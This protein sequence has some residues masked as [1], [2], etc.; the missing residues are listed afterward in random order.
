MKGA[1]PRAGGL[2]ALSSAQAIT[3]G[4]ISL[5]QNA[6]RA[7]VRWPDTILGGMH[8]RPEQNPSLGNDDPLRVN[9]NAERVLVGGLAAIVTFISTLTKAGNPFSSIVDI[10]GGY[11]ILAPL[12]VILG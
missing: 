1:L 7:G 2:G 3:D 5:R 10:V 8:G 9:S 6:A 12:I 11:F 4:S